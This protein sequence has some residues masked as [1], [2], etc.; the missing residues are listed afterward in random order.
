MKFLLLIIFLLFNLNLQSQT[1]FNNHSDPLPFSYSP[2]SFTHDY[3]YARLRIHYCG[4]SSDNATIDSISFF[5][6]SIGTAYDTI[7]VVYRIY[8]FED[9]VFN[10][11]TTVA[12][13]LS[14]ASLVFDDTIPLNSGM[15][16]MWLN[17][18]FTNPYIYNGGSL[19]IVFESVN[20]NHTRIDSSEISFRHNWWNGSAAPFYGVSYQLWNSDSLMPAD[21]GLIIYSNRPNF[22]LAI[23]NDDSCNFDACYL[24]QLSYSPNP[25]TML[26]SI[27]IGLDLPPLGNGFTYNWQINLGFVWAN[28]GT[29]I[30]PWIKFHP[31]DYYFSIICNITCNG[32]IISTSSTPV[33]VSTAEK[34]KDDLTNLLLFP[35]PALNHFKITGNDKPISTIIIYNQQSQIVKKVEMKKENPEVDISELKAGLYFIHVISADKIRWLKLVKE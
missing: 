12:N 1:P 3:D 18:P 5:I 15:D 24:P 4:F 23:H 27:T 9:S 32:V 16:S 33:I 17:I 21:S 2:I 34:H 7:D 14:G 8:M 26:D 25:V 10:S 6:D 29:T 13:M 31:F 30:Q 35:N 19:N 11:Q 28:L 20:S 22:K